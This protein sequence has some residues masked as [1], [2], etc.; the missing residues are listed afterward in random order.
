[1]QITFFNRRT[2]EKPNVDADELRELALASMRDADRA[3]L[4]AA[5]VLPVLSDLSENY[6]APRAAYDAM[7]E[8]ICQQAKWSHTL[9][10]LHPEEAL[11]RYQ[12]AN[13]EQARDDALWDDPDRA[14]V[15]K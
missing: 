12:E 2:K 5:K 9:G 3:I 13:R 7:V 11:Q 8:F 6:D 14:A 4:T 1:M 15:P 10:L